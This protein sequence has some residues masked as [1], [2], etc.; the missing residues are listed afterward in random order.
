MGCNGPDGQPAEEDTPSAMPHPPPSMDQHAAVGQC[1]GQHRSPRACRQPPP[2][3]RRGICARSR[4]RRGTD[5]A[6]RAMP[7]RA[8]RARPPPLTRPAASAKGRRSGLALRVAIAIA[9]AFRAVSAPT[10]TSADAASITVAKGSASSRMTT[11]P[12]AYAAFAAHAMLKIAE[13]CQPGPRQR[14][15]SRPHRDDECQ[16]DEVS[17]AGSG[18]RDAN[19]L[20][21]RPARRSEFLA[22]ESPQVPRAPDLATAVVEDAQRERQCEEVPLPHARRAASQTSANAVAAQTTVARAGAAPV[23]S[24]GPRQPA[25][26]RRL[27]PFACARER[28]A[29][30]GGT[31][32]PTGSVAAT[33][34]TT[35]SSSAPYSTWKRRCATGK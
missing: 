10:A 3:R 35:G 32:K 12:S 5:R 6:L 16:S 17:G 27:A 9:S 21:E 30:A 34:S 28:A 14:P 2:G 22:P 4:R 20:A 8:A 23:R 25:P 15:P 31:T 18:G 24:P 1:G 29:S 33:S 19:A 26:R 7:P 13:P 11:R